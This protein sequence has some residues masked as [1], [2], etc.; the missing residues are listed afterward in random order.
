MKFQSYNE[1]D[2]TITRFIEQ[3]DGD[4]QALALALHDLQVR[5]VP[6]IA[7]LCQSRDITPSSIQ[8]T[9]QI[10]AIPT[11]AFRDLA[12]TSIPEQDRAHH[13]ESSGTTG[14]Q[15]SRHWHHEKSLELYKTSLHPPFQKYVLNNKEWKGRTLALTPLP[16]EARHSS[17]AHMAG[18]VLGS[19]TT[20]AGER[21]NDGWNINWHACESAC[22]HAIKT[23]RP[24]LIFGPAFSFLHW[25]DSTDTLHKL[26]WESRIMETG[27]YKGR[28]RVLAKNEFHV[29]LSKRLGISE[30]H[31]VC[32]YGMCE[33][34]SQ[35]YD[36]QIGVEKE[37]AFRFPHWAQPII[38]NPETGNPCGEGEI[39]LLRI[40][41]LANVYSSVAIQTQDLARSVSDGFEL[42]G[43]D[44]TATPRG[45]SLNLLQQT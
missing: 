12:I 22:E 31:I 8:Q 34:N 44:Q 7:A 33:L 1:A 41:D 29:L 10:P 3:G 20:H 16:T 45:C 43:R 6:A 15:P 42:L 19:D 23:N 17:L 2:H 27:G 13:F 5:H 26:P 30:S 14:S 28:S 37:R 36:R 32:E 11:T 18:H 24:L 35:A 4:F 40:I 39:G 9:H 21:T 25:L 38:I